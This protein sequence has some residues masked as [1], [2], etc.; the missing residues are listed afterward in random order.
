MDDVALVQVS[1]ATRYA[2]RKKECTRL[3]SRKAEQAKWQ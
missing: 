3:Y 1:H 2:R